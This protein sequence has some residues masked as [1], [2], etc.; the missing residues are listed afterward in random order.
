MADSIAKKV[1]EAVKDYRIIYDKSEKDFRDSKKKENAMVEIA[2]K[3]G[4]TTED[5]SR[6][7]KSQRSNFGKYLNSLE[8][9]SGSSRDKVKLD[10]EQEHLRWL[11]CHIAPRTTKT[12]MQKKKQEDNDT[13]TSTTTYTVPDLADSD[14]EIE[15][16][17]AMSRGKNCLGLS[18]Q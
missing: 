15:E 2:T 3:L 10:P 8:V 13:T 16:T 11:I 12:S 1:M 18:K 7:Y 5:V 14:Q 4:I 6:H 9:P 17:A